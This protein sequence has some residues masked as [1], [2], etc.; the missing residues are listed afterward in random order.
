MGNVQINPVPVYQ[1][2][3]CGFT[4]ER[5]KAD[6]PEKVLLSCVVEW[7]RKYGEVIQALDTSDVS[8]L[9]KDAIAFIVPGMIVLVGLTRPATE[10]IRT[11][12]PSVKQDYR[13]TIDSV[14]KEIETYKEDLDETLEAW[15]LSLDHDFVSKVKE[16]VKEAKSREQAVTKDW[17]GLLDPIRH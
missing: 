3:A 5:M 6:N 12:L 16:A 11:L 15:S 1:A 17:R 14:L 10:H 7:S 4:L 9:D 8:N 13:A 2:V